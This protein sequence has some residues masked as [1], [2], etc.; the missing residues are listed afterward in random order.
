MAAIFAF[1]APVFAHHGALEYDTQH[2]TTVLGGTITRFEFRNPHVRI[3]W[4]TKNDQGV[5]Q[6]WAAQATNPN[7]LYRFGWNHYQTRDATPDGFGQSLQEWRQLHAPAKDCSSEWTR[8]AS[9][10]IASS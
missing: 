4:E 6:M 10:T 9:S 8:T 5:G 7:T 2:E 3:F 1:A